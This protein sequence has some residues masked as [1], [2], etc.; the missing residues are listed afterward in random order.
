M[1]RLEMMRY[2]GSESSSETGSAGQ[3]FLSDHMTKREH[4]AERMKY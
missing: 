2:V 4:Y 3:V 1:R